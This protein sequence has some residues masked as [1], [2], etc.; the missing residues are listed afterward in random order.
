MKGIL[1]VVRYPRHGHLRNNC[2]AF[3]PLSLRCR[4]FKSEDAKEGVKGDT[5]APL[6]PWNRKMMKTIGILTGC[7]FLANASFG[8][9]IPVLPQFAKELGLG[10]FGVG[11]ILSV[12]AIARVF[13][14][15]PLGKAAD[16]YGRKPLMVCG[17][18]IGAI[19]A[20]STGF[21]NSL[22]ML[23]PARLL[24]GI[25]TAS[26]MAGTSAYMADITSKMPSYRAQ[27]MGVQH[28]M[29]TAAF[30][31]G[32]AIGGFLAEAYG[33]RPAFMIVGMAMAASGMG[34]SF[35]E[36]TKKKDSTEIPPDKDD[37]GKPS[38]KVADGVLALLKDKEQQGII[39]MTGALFLGYTAQLT[40]LPLHAS[41]V[42]SATTGEIGLL[43]SASSCSGLVGAPIGGYISDKWG[44]KAALIPSALLCASSAVCL[45]MCSTY[46][47]FVAAIVAW[48]LGTS[49]M[50]PGLMALAA[51]I[52]PPHL[53]GEALSLSRQAG[54]IAFLIGPL[55]LGAIAQWSSCGVGLMVTACSYV[56]S[57]LY[58][59]RKVSR[60]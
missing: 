16:I 26:S 42:L 30:V 18:I 43:F 23:L 3:T 19:G 6:T 55:T 45:S 9:I 32:P 59:H 33:A 31:A 8:I 36:E 17:N 1:R 10:A 50:H 44:R 20:C 47:T 40:L 51:D 21:A 14:N 37:N 28:T 24:V 56:F 35:L 4:R 57:A 52:A 48:G 11:A 27:I 53:R 38:L 34:Y 41:A 22:F 2:N 13:L 25:G 54:D 58:F 15:I 39:V 29:V 5:A 49:I 12:P 46:P 60:K 7:Q